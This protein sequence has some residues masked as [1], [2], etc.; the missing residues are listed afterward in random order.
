MLQER[1]GSLIG[2]AS[3]LGIRAPQTFQDA[4]DLLTLA[5]VAQE[6]D[7]P[8]RAWLSA[9]GARGSRSCGTCPS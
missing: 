7:R 9:S 1:L 8:E 2:L 5:G 3:V 4:A 6:P